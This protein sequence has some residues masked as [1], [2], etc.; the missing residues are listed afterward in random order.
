MVTMRSC[1]CEFVDSTL[2]DPME[3]SGSYTLNLAEPYDRYD[4]RAELASSRCDL[5]GVTNIVLP[6]G[7][8]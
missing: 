1:D 6:R 2:F 8:V 5:L 7:I 3:P 4:C